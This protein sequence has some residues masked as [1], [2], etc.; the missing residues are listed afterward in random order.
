MMAALEKHCEQC[1]SLFQR[2]KR[3]TYAYFAQQR[4]CSSG[5]VGQY[6]SAAADAARPSMEDAF[7]RWVDK[8][9]DCWEWTGA[10]DPQGYG[11]FC[12]AKKT[13]KAHRIA[14]QL[15]GRSFRKGEYACHHCDNPG[16]VN[17]D[18]IYVGTPKDNMRD[19]LER[20]R[21][22]HGSRCHMA[23]LTEANVRE[24]RRGGKTDQQWAEQFGV[25]RPTVTMARSGT[26]WRHI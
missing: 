8:G 14:V 9:G 5:C 22:P 20:G 16:C 24:I 7:Y 15:D 23:R 19:A 1:G 21:F 18:H 11:V 13:Y 3:N 17:P 25:S 2:D 4:F 26:T 6:K 10:R 12:Y